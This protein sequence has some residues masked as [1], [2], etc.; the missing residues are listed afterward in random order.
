M[1]HIN[2]FFFFA[3]GDGLVGNRLSPYII[4]GEIIALALLRVALHGN[5]SSF[6]LLMET[7]SAWLG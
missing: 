7:C 2:A 4:S 5:A 6:D 1:L 3:M